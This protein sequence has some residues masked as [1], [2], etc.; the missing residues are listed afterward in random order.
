MMIQLHRKEA[1]S[2][3]IG[4]LVYV[5]GPDNVRCFPPGQTVFLLPCNTYSVIIIIILKVGIT[6]TKVDSPP[7]YETLVNKQEAGIVGL[8]PGGGGAHIFCKCSPLSV[9]DRSLNSN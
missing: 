9:R 7:S 4:G 5:H 3:D 6:P 8:G 2:A 1:H